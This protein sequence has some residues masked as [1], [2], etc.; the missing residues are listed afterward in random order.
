MKRYRWTLVTLA[1]GAVLV[2]GV[3]PNWAAKKETK[4]AEVKPPPPAPAFTL[5]DHN[6]KKVSLA[7]HKGKVVVLEWVNWDCPFSKRQHTSGVT[8]KLA[9]AYADKG[10]VWLGVNSTHFANVKVNKK[11]AEGHKLPY[12]VLDDHTGAV[13]RAY[14]AKT[15]PHLYVLGKD[16]RVAYQG[17]IDDNPRGK[18]KTGVTNYVAAALDALVAD[19][20]VATPSTKPYGCSVKYAKLPAPSGPAAPAFTLTDQSGETVSLAD[21]KGKVVVLEWINWDCPFVKRHHRGGAMEA[22]AAKYAEKGVVWLG[23]NSTHYANVAANKKSATAYKTPYPVLDDHTGEVGR[24]YGAKTTPHLF[25]IVPNGA[26]AY[27][28]AI[29]SDPRGRSGEATNYVAA[30]LDELLAGKAVSTPTTKSYG[31]SVKYAR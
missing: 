26:I 17:A 12:P 31:C 24:A 22:L 13:G 1:L 23:V 14:G 5:T 18:K 27:Q 10:V 28:G 15:T 2:A 9:E 25:V 19:K 6:G 30:A 4:E 21:Y 20:K 8:K 11:S 16:G 3:V 7:D 29:D